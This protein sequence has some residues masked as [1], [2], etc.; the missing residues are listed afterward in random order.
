MKLDDWRALPRDKRNDLAR[1]AQC[2]LLE[3]FRCCANKR[4]R[5]D[6]WCAGADPRSCKDRLWISAKTKPKT[7]RNAMARFEDMTYL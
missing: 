5:R 7:L 3:A 6:R 4:C 2:D 1:R